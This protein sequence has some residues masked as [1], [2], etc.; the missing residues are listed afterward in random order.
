MGIDPRGFGCDADDC[1]EP[2]PEFDGRVSRF[3]SDFAGATWI[4]PVS[5][6]AFG[7][8]VAYGCPDDPASIAKFR[9]MLY[10]V[11]AAPEVCAQISAAEAYQR[12]CASPVLQDDYA[13]WYRNTVATLAYRWDNRDVL[14][15]NYAF[16]ENDEGTQSTGGYHFVL[17]GGLGV[18]GSLPRI[19]C[20]EAADREM[21]LRYKLDPTQQD[22]V[23]NRRSFERGGRIINAGAKLVSGG[24]SSYGL[25][26][27][28]PRGGTANDEYGM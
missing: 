16:E 2:N 14:A 19:V 23:K 12:L 8:P 7:D 3:L 6:D 20:L 11:L 28:G 17:L 21:N 18:D 13:R 24:R 5:Y 1:V 9:Q 4:R 25:L 15:S 27:D 22:I 26:F 10:C